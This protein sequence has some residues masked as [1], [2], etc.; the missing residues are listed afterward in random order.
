[1]IILKSKKKKFGQK[2]KNLQN[3]R[4]FH[5]LLCDAGLS[6]IAAPSTAA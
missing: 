2:I 3:Y 5:T 4:H 6:F 1:M